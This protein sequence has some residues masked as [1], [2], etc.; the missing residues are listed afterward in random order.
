[1][2]T[3]DIQNYVEE[4]Y[5]DYMDKILLADGYE[6][7]FMG[8]VESFGLEPRALYDYEMCVEQI[9]SEYSPE[10]TCMDERDEMAR[11]FMEYNV[12]QAYVGDHTPAFMRHLGKDYYNAIQD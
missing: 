10:A 1:M 12:V 9:K 5:P 6:N 11:E 3:A 4:N 8:V 2:T 7:A